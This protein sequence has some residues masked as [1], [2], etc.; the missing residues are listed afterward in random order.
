M[1]IVVLW[2]FA[3]CTGDT[4]VHG[5]IGGNM[6]QRTT[7]FV[8]VLALL[9]TASVGFGA[10]PA[11]AN[12]TEDRLFDSAQRAAG[13]D[14]VDAQSLDLGVSVDVKHDAAVAGF[15]DFEVGLAPSADV[16][17]TTVLPAGVRVM[18]R[19][20]RGAM[21]TDFR[22]D[23]PAGATLIPQDGGYVVAIDA[24]GTRIALAEIDEPWAV[25]A[26]GEEVRTSYSLD[27]D[28]LTQSLHGSEIAYPVVADP[29]ITV[30][31]AGASD[32]PGAYWNMT[33]IQVKIISAVTV[34]ALGTA[35]AGGCVGAG[36]IPSV[37]YIIQGLC[38]YL[39]APTVQNIWGGVTS[40]FR[41]ASVQNTGCYQLKI[42][43]IGK[44]IHKVDRKN[45]A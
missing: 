30:G 45:C 15:G 42:A 39:G 29:T 28:V 41:N 5:N 14:P 11:N 12:S 37:G 18:S 38:G 21:S 34:S 3:D 9:T 19:I 7:S 35:L 8:A 1:D 27:G 10:M 17:S 32:G 31:L 23:L 40:I 6:I 33:G 4:V 13:L 25:D 44:S 2:C 22:V 16:F 36:K 24:G 43:P 20:D 26:N